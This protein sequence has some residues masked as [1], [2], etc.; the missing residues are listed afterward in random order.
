MY[1]LNFPNQIEN[2]QHEIMILICF[3]KNDAQEL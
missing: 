1:I 3:S 2:I